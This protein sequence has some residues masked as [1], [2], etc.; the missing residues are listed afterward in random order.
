MNVCYLHQ[1]QT[2]LYQ[3]L[4][5][6]TPPLS[7]LSLTIIL[8]LFISI[9]SLW[10]SKTEPTLVFGH[11]PFTCTY[12]IFYFVTYITWLE[13]CNVFTFITAIDVM[14]TH[15]NIFWSILHISKKRENVNSIENGQEAASKLKRCSYNLRHLHLKDGQ[16]S[17]LTQFHEFPLQPVKSHSDTVK[18]IS[19]SHMFPHVAGCHIISVASTDGRTI[20]N[21]KGKGKLV[22]NLNIILMLLSLCLYVAMLLWL[23]PLKETLW[24]Y[25]SWTAEKK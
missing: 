20:Q 3:T 14:F 5:K 17:E 2:I 1:I 6:E 25:G 13:M 4:H 16:G 18:H 10:A 9:W 15:I 12:A 24:F 22:L 21:A 7:T 23:V 11:I 19:I 8:L